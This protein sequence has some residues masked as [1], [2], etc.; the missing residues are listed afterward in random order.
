MKRRYIILIM[1]FVCM[2]IVAQDR[3][4]TVGD[5]TFKMMQKQK[6]KLEEI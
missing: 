2:D 3:T 6:R 5:I 4:F 1:L